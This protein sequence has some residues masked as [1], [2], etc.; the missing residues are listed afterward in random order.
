[1]KSLML[2]FHVLGVVVWVGGMFFAYMALRPAASKILEA[3]ER[4]PLWGAT[5]HRFFSWVWLSIV[6]IL[7]SGF[8]MVA[9]LGGF[10]AAGWS[11]LAMLAIGVSMMVIFGHVYFGPF[12]KLSTCAAA[13]N[14]S[15][16]S[17][18]LGKIRFLVGLNLLLG[19]LV[20]A[21]A[22]VGKLI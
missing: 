12:A 19:L 11:V 16:G 21:V 18:A 8:G 14:W 7:I 3:P 13:R 22:T 2:L 20:I 5:L 6:A 10:R 1:M 17:I 4:L 9:A 15:E